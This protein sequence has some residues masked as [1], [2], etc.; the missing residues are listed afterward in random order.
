VAVQFRFMFGDASL[1]E[2]TTGLT[3]AEYARSGFF[4]LVAVAALVLPLLLAADG[5][6]TG[7]D[8]R[9]R[10]I[11][12]G[13]SAVMIS[14]LFVI[15]ASA[16]ARMRLYVE[17]YGLTEQR[18]YATALM[19]WLAVVFLWFAATAMRGRRRHFAFGSIIAAYAGLIGL[20]FLS[21]DAL[22]ARVNVNRVRAGYDFDAAYAA[23]LSADAVPTLIEALDDLAPEDRCVAAARVLERWTRPDESD[24]RSWNLSRSKAMAVVDENAQR[25]R[26]HSCDE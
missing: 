12:R 7:E 10:R 6:M 2:A 21:P 1:V 13:L 22:I 15:M 5:A 25:L 14:L 19:A 16:L 20:N 17:A 18:L 24:W 3:Y 26:S 8:A 9:G 23:S 4:Q 11:F